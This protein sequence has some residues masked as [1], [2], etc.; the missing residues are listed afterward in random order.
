MSGWFVDSVK[1]SIRLPTSNP[2]KPSNKRIGSL[3]EVYRK[4]RSFRSVSTQSMPRYRYNKIRP[5][6]Q[7][8]RKERLP[9]GCQ[10]GNHSKYCINLHSSVDTKMD[11]RERKRGPPADAIGDE[12]LIRLF[13]R[14]YT[15]FTSPTR[16]DRQLRAEENC[17]WLYYGLPA[18]KLTLF[19]TKRSLS[20][21]LLVMSYLV[22]PSVCF[23]LAQITIAAKG[24][25]TV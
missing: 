1:I 12:K 22:T 11:T 5:D 21:S 17:N 6:L 7:R 20:N 4:L 8:W 15:R 14:L 16:E 9:K 19:T 3:R 23:S 25:G 18:D 13:N 24:G 10:Q 2:I